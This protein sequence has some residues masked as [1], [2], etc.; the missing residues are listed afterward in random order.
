MAGEREME[1]CSFLPFFYFL[2]GTLVLWELSINLAHALL[3]II[4]Y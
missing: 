3:V 4:G 1:V 2:G